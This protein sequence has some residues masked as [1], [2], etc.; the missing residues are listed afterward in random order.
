MRGPAL[1]ILFSLGAFFVLIL[2]LNVA[3][4]DNY[5][6]GISLDAPAP[7]V[8]ENDPIYRRILP[9]HVEHPCETCGTCAHTVI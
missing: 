3:E 4:R 8:G 5:A 2:I 7:G 1:W 9:P 6:S